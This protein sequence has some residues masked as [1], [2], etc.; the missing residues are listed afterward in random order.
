MARSLLA[1]AGIGCGGWGLYIRH[2]LKPLDAIG[3][4]ARRFGAGDFSEP[5]PARYADDSGELS[6]LAASLNTMG[7]DVHQMLEAKRALLL[8]ISHELR[9]PLARARLNAELLPYPQST[10]LPTL[11]DFQL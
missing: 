8:A 1:L 2:L 9:S 10:F 11:H 7:R 3:A 6:D 4:R 5:I